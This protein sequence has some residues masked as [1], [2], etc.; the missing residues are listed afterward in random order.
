[1]NVLKVKKWGAFAFCGL[2]PM[3]LSLG[4]LFTTSDVI[5]S[6]I[7]GMFGM[8]V[9]IIV[10]TKIYG[11]PLMAV[12][13][14]DGIL[15][16][17][18]DSTGVLTPFLLRVATPYLTGNIGDEQLR[19]TFDRQ[20][21]NYL[22]NPKQGTIGFGP[23]KKL[24]I[25]LDEAEYK[26]NIMNLGGIPTLIYNKHMGAFMSKE[27]LSKAETETFVQH[28]V[29]HLNRRT[30]ELSSNIRDFARYII[31]QTRP[32]SPF[33]KKPW[34]IA[35]LIIIMVVGVAIF[36]GPKILEQLGILHPAAAQAPAGTVVIPS[37]QIPGSNIPTTGK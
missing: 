33:W 36:M 15:A 23:D 7:A 22:M 4:F 17:T 16:V 26:N 30:D 35:V 11:H 6:L 13:E 31:E 21:V 3:A 19:T 8:V 37:T 14:G 20:T 34:F 18:M 10:S 2:V 29:L 1:M 5:V 28:L 24:I 32:Q 27:M 25:T 9:M 12:I